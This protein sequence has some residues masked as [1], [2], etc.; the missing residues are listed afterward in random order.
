MSA[1][2]NASAID[3]ATIVAYRETHYTVHC[4]PELTLIVGMAHAGLASLHKA[5]GV[6]CSAFVTACNP[7]SK[8]LTD[9]ENTQRQAALEREV[10]AR[11]L[12]MFKGVGRHPNSD[13]PGEPSVLILG[14][15]LQAA[16]TLGARFEQNAII[17]SA[18][19]AVPQLILLR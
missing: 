14:L 19:D 7:F 9:S 16:R 11:G 18:A 2:V 12:H 6:G 3:P 5:V 17:W 1:S 8:I 15:D 13:W 4:A 10:R